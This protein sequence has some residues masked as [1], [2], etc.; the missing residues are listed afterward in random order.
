MRQRDTVIPVVSMT[1]VLSLELEPREKNH[2][3]GNVTL[4]GV[5]VV[6]RHLGSE[7]KRKHFRS[8]H[9][10]VCDNEEDCHPEGG[11]QPEEEELADGFE[12]YH[13]ESVFQSTR[14]EPSSCQAN[15]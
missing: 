3:C 14:S 11:C 8:P 10:D 4:R 6:E 2:V 13:L 9:L 7:I 1:K 5:D 15:G 12:L